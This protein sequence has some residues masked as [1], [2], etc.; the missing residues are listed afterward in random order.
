MTFIIIMGVAL[1]AIP[2]VEQL[3]M[4]LRGDV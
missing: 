3:A 4:I 2:A 1:V